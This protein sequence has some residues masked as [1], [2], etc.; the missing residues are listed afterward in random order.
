MTTTTKV[1]LL[2]DGGAGKSALVSS[3]RVGSF[4]QQYIPTMGAEIHPLD[5]EGHSF[6]LFDF[7]G[8][9]KYAATQT[10]TQMPECDIALLVYD[11]TSS[12]MQKNIAHWASLIPGTSTKIVRTKN[13]CVPQ[14]R[15]NSDHLSVSSRT[16]ENVAALRSFLL[17]IARSRSN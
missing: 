7:A 11:G 14:K 16:G 1:F 17:D 10:L 6:R 12:L 2:G 8:Q 5:I 3:L 9:E 15:P 4:P 13:D